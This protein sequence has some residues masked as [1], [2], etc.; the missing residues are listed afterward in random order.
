[1]RRG[2]QTRAQSCPMFSSEGKSDE[3]IPGRRRPFCRVT[4]RRWPAYRCPSSITGPFCCLT[5]SQ[6]L[7]GPLS[8]TASSTRLTWWRSDSSVPRTPRSSIPGDGL[9]HGAK[10][11]RLGPPRT[12]KRCARCL[13]PAVSRGACERPRSGA[14]TVAD[15]GRD[16]H[17][18]RRKAS[19]ALKPIHRLLHNS[20][21]D[22]MVVAM[23]AASQSRPLLQSEN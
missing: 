15:E 16:G 10:W 8:A 23:T 1:M 11:P 22:L 12:G 13:D 9:R 20:S 14:S 21:V 7:A 19:P 3:L 2:G 6:A 17:D 5:R 18:G 4:E